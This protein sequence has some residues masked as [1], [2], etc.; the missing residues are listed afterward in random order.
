MNKQIMMMIPVPCDDIIVRNIGSEADTAPEKLGCAT[1]SW[2]GNTDSHGFAP[3]QDIRNRIAAC[4]GCDTHLSR[5]RH[6]MRDEYTRANPR[7]AQ[8]GISS[9]MSRE[10][11]PPGPL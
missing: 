10:K 1:K 9:S 5:P 6:F 7:V 4:R 8:N 3:P 2:S 11:P